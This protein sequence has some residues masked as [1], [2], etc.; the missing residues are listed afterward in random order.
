M[1][2]I[3]AAMAYFDAPFWLFAVGLMVNAGIGT[4][5]Q[6]GADAYLPGISTPQ[7]SP[8]MFSKIRIGTNVGW[9]VGPMLGAFLAR[10]PFWLMFLMTAALCFFGAWYTGR[11]CGSRPRKARHPGEAASAAAAPVLSV[12][13][14]LRDHRLTRL[15]ACSFLLFLLTSQLYSV[16]SVYSTGVVGISKTMLGIVYSVNGFVI[17]F[18]QLP[19]TW[20]FDRLQLSPAMRMTSGALLYT[21]GYFSLGFATGGA[22]LVAS[23]FVLTLGE[24]AVMPALY[25]QVG[26]YAPTGGSGLYGRAGTGARRRLC[27]RPTRFSG[28]ARSRELQCCSA[29]AR[30]P[31]GRGGVGFRR[32]AAGT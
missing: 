15:L 22:M 11:V 18:C 28:V 2:L 19:V 7:T 30:V 10:T 14:M 26:R 8:R 29:D 31:L 12:G 6:V 21:A 16:L 5:F 32:I 20:V 25:S 27:G 9:A 23:V 3:F 13:R 24:A 1:F 4:F 17:I